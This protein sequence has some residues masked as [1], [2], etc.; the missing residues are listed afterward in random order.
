M[1]EPSARRRAKKLNA[2][3]SGFYFFKKG[4]LVFDGRSLA[5]DAPLKRC[6]LASGFLFLKGALVFDGRSL[7][8]DSGH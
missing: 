8:R 3:A 2:L 5:R 7:A 4:V 1:Q 6:A